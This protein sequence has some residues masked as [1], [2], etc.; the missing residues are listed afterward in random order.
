MNNE[1]PDNLDEVETEDNL[2]F[3]RRKVTEGVTNALRRILDPKKYIALLKKA[4]SIA[5][6]IAFDRP[7]ENVP[8]ATFTI[9]DAIRDTDIPISKL[10]EEVKSDGGRLEKPFWVVKLKDLSAIEAI[11]VEPGVG[12]VCLFRTQMDCEEYISSQPNRAEVVCDAPVNLDDAIATLKE[13]RSTGHSYVV[14]NPPPSPYKR[15]TTTPI[16]AVID[17]LRNRGHIREFI[18]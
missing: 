13:V 7:L 2:S 10:L 15:P 9:E 1:L 12:A 11:E 16:E 18:V 5:I 3:I 6:H 4:A 14:I 17:H 8:V